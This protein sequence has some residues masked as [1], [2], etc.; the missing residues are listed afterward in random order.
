MNKTIRYVLLA[1]AVGLVAAFGPLYGMSH[2]QTAS[3]PLAGLYQSPPD[4]PSFGTYMG[5]HPYYTLNYMNVIGGGSNPCW[6]NG[7]YPTVTALG[8]FDANV[9]G[10]NDPVAA[11]NGS[12]NG[13]YANYAANVIGPCASTIYALRVDWEWGGNWF[14]FSPYYSNIGS[15]YYPWIS[16]ATWIAGFQN[17]VN[18]IRSNPATANIKIAWDY[19]TTL[20]YGSNVMA[21]YPGDAYVD[22]ISSDI[23]FN[24]QWN[25]PTSSGAWN[26]YNQP[27]GINDWAA[28]AAAHSKP[29]AAWEWCDAYTDGYNLTQFSNWIKANNFVAQ[30]YWDYASPT[31]C[32]LQ[33]NPSAYSAYIAAWQ[34]WTASGTFWGGIIPAGPYIPWGY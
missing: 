33:S 11:A 6:V 20:I 18:A 17:F 7:G 4:N 24:P 26:F 23:Y 22:I 9:N 13:I 10:I 34:N 2:A 12:Y 32:K 28:F 3:A 8:H 30:S 5:Y 31:N 25:G 21:Y 1:F 29:M 15:Y 19:P 27:G 14:G 16:P